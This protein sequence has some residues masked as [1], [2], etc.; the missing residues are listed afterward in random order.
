MSKRFR[1]FLSAILVL[2]ALSLGVAR[3]QSADSDDAPRSNDKGVV[4]LQM[5]AR[6][7][8]SS[9]STRSLYIY[10]CVQ[11]PER[12]VPYTKFVSG[13]N[14]FDLQEYLHVKMAFED[15]SIFKTVR[16]SD[17]ELTRKQNLFEKS[18]PAVWKRLRGDVQ[19]QD[20]EAR[21][22]LEEI[23]VFNALLEKQESLET[24]VQQLRTRFKVQLFN[25]N[26]T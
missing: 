15:N 5:L 3:A 16:F 22:V 6:V 11:S 26:A 4:R 12:C 7:G 17:S 20:V 2:S 18:H 10:V 9:I 8:G 1:N 19:M 13:D 21:T 25:Q 24:W 14:G 23:A